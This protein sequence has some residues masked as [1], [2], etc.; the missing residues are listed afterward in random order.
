MTIR[1]LRYVVSLLSCS[2][3]VHMQLEHLI[4]L[5]LLLISLL[6]NER[7]STQIVDCDQPHCITIILTYG[8]GSCMCLKYDNGSQLPL[9]RSRQVGQR[10]NMQKLLKN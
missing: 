7:S 10:R 3:P 6:G 9:Y 8:P 2:V 1:R 5:P 4:M